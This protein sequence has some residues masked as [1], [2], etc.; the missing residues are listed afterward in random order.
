MQYMRRAKGDKY[1]KQNN[2]MSNDKSPKLVLI[3]PHDEIHSYGLR[4]LSAYL[5]SR[6]VEVSLIFC[7]IQ[8]RFSAYI[9]R[10]TGNALPPKV[11]DDIARIAQN[12][13]AIGISL[14]TDQLPI[15]SEI[16]NELKKRLPDTPV[17][18]GGIHPT[19]VPADCA[20]VTDYVCVGEGYEPAYELLMALKQGQSVPQILG[21]G[22][23]QDNKFCF[24]GVRAPLT[25]IDKLPFAD[26]GIEEHYLRV[27]DTIQTM[28]V[29]LL[30][31]SMG[32][33]YTSFF[34]HGCPFSCSYCCNSSLHEL[35]P[36]YRL[37]RKHSPEYIA[38]E[39]NKMKQRYPFI[40]MVKFN[41]DSFMSLSQEEMERF[42]KLQNE[43][44]V[45]P[46]VATGCIPKLVTEEKMWLMIKAGLRRT[47]V[48]VQTGN[49]R[50]LREVF[51]RYTNNDDIIRCSEILN[52]FKKDLVAVSYDFILD[53]PWEKPKETLDSLK[54]ILRLK[55]P[56][57]LNL[58]SLKLYPLSAL[59]QKELA[60]GSDKKTENFLVLNNS[61]LNFLIAL[62]GLIP[63]PL[64]LQKFLL[65]EDKIRANKSAP[66]IL[67]SVLNFIT[68]ARRVY[69][70]VRKRDVTMLPFAIARF[71]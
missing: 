43:N 29:D 60:D 49:Q 41:D 54:L 7:P 32:F 27:G 20:R 52:K 42:A 48:G 46:F 6:D 10:G 17:I 25:D 31:K 66:K 9:S 11:L 30:K 22:Y 2:S 38:E 16:T 50:I 3:S 5:K 1:L 55:R 70:H 61:Y 21:I 36:G 67:M 51:N 19:L 64:F 37:V 69:H 14:M 8:S 53:N 18:W 4:S 35:H 65:A 44:G 57:C 62:A 26:Y 56:F 68:E 33:W 40:K 15:V 59:T 39:I 12:A 28:T 24:P 47:R 58:Y 23:I 63:I 34:T 71:L 45:M 13:T